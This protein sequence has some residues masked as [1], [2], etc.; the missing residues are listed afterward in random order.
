MPILLGLLATSVCFNLILVAWVLMAD[1]SSGFE[2]LPREASSK[3]PGELLG[4]EK[5]VLKWSLV[6]GPHPFSGKGLVYTLQC[7]CNDPDFRGVLTQQT[8]LWFVYTA[9]PHVH[10][11]V[12]ISQL[13]CKVPARPDSLLRV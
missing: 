12:T 13:H 2:K 5:E 7:Q 10:T 4:V 1:G 8:Y 11:A 6:S 9:Q 3:H